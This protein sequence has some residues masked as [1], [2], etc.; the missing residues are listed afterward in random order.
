[1]IRFWIPGIP[2]STQTGTSVRIPGRLKIE[3]GKLVQSKDR[4]FPSRRGTPWS[5]WCALKMNRHRPEKLLNGALCVFL[6]FHL[7]VPKNRKTFYPVDKPDLENL[8]TGLLNAGNTRLW[9]DDSVICRLVLD[10]VY[11]EDEPGVEVGVEPL[12]EPG[13]M[14]YAPG[15]QAM[16]QALR[17]SGLVSQ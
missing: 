5:E 17:K 2:R 13:H 1:V 16:Q 12:P 11:A 6:I 10:K 15:L 4:V 14:E 9:T 8:I 7:P 3:D